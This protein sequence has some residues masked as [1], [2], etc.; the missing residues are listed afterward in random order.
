MSKP[1]PL[2]YSHQS[3]ESTMP[4]IQNHL[5]L[6]CNF[7]F[8]DVFMCG[9]HDTYIEKEVAIHLVKTHIFILENL[10]L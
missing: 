9:H 10:K 7:G 8:P 3:C 1:T 5:H 2:V 4:F 6:C